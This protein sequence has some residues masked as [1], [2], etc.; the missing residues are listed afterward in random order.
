MKLDWAMLANAADGKDGL[1]YILGGGW[2]TTW[3]DVYPSPFIGSVV[4]RVL[5]TPE[6]TA[7]VHHA[8]LRIVDD[9]RGL[10]APAIN[11]PV[12]LSIPPG[13][14]EGWDVGGLVGVTLTGLE[15]PKAGSYAIE[16]AVDNTTLTLLRFRCVEGPPPAGR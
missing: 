5:F 2:D 16:I 14:P 3:R 6:E 11:F 9:Q 8:Q 13:H 4:F 15:I 12:P 10:I 7:A 1:A